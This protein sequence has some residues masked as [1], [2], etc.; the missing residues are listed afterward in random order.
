MPIPSLRGCFDNKKLLSLVCK[1]LVTDMFRR[2]YFLRLE[3]EFILSITRKPTEVFWGFFKYLS[4]I[5][6]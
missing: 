5:L 6:S 1:S 2:S 4:N 3:A